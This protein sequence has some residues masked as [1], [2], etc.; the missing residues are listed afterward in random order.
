MKFLPLALLTAAATLIAGCATPR[1]DTY[2]DE[3]PVLD[4]RQYFDGEIEA[5][6][7]AEPVDR[8]LAQND[9]GEVLV[10]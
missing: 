3:R 7:R 4:L 9:D 8:C 10:S 2:R 1:V 6:A 5:H